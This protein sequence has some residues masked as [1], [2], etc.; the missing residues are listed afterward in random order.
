MKRHTP[1]RRHTWMKRR[2]KGPRRAQATRDPEYLR[3]VRTQPCVLKFLFRCWAATEAHH[4]SVDHGLGQKGPDRA[5]V[6]MC[7]VCHGLWT[8]HAGPF[9][10][11]SKQRRR[12]LAA[13]WIADTQA[14]HAR[15]PVG[16]E[17]AR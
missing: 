13:T 8:A 5:A 15:G 2:R 17:A 11:L 10:G 14:A 16:L 4:A 1:L 9:L 7:R 6:P 3:W 12:E